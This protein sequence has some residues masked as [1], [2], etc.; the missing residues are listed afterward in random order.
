MSVLLQYLRKHRTNLTEG[1]GIILK[2]THTKK[3]YL[4]RLQSKYTPR[5]KAFSACHPYLPMYP[6]HA[7]PSLAGPH[8]RWT[9]LEKRHWAWSPHDSFLSL[10]LFSLPATSLLDSL[11]LWLQPEQRNS[12][13]HFTAW[14]HDH[15]V[16]ALGVTAWLEVQWQ[17]GGYLSGTDSPIFAAIQQYHSTNTPLPALL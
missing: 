6:F 9:W 11:P 2:K 16:Q 15:R 14:S 12:T 7:S 1:K 8:S 17:P 10:P 3:R 13:G 5:I 4:S